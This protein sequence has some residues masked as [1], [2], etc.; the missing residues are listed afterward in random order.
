[1]REDRIGDAYQH[2]EAAYAHTKTGTIMRRFIF[3][4]SLEMM[5]AFHR[6]GFA[7][8]PG[9]N[10]PEQFD[11]CMIGPNLHLRGVA[12]RIG[13]EEK[14]RQGESGNPV[15]DEKDDAFQPDAEAGITLKIR[16]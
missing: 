8:I 4:W 14:N 11:R 9:W 12:L 1:M 7:P 3:P 5:H 16:R 2:F 6:E 15:G 13:A 10:F